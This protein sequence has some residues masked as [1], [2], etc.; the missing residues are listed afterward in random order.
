MLLHA[1]TCLPQVKADLTLGGINMCYGKAHPPL[2]GIFSTEI[3]YTGVMERL[4][5][6]LIGGIFST[7]HS[8]ISRCSGKA[9]PPLGGIFSTD[10]NPI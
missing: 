2:G 1:S 6:H 4:I 7:E 5:H 3:P 10:Y 8:P 9:D